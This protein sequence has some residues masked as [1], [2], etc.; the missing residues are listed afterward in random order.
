MAD[1]ASHVHRTRGGVVDE[2]GHKAP[3]SERVRGGFGASWEACEGECR[4]REGGLR[5]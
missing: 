1:P 2:A 3:S 4:G 5:E